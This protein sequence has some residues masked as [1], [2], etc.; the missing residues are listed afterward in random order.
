MAGQVIEDGYNAVLTIHLDGSV[1]SSSKG[2]GN[3]S[4]MWVWVKGMAAKKTYLCK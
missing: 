2:M 3:A 4:I 1:V